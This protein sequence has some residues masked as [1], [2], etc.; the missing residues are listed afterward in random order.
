MHEEG[1]AF[2]GELENL[3]RWVSGAG[4]LFGLAS[5]ATSSGDLTSNF[6]AV[7]IAR[8]G[9]IRVVVTIGVAATASACVS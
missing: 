5:A 9:S 6:F 1:G 2:S 8:L 3:M 7:F 4:I